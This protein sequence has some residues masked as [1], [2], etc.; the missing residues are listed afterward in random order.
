MLERRYIYQALRDPAAAGELTVGDLAIVTREKAQSA[1][2]FAKTLGNIEITQAVNQW[3]SGELM[4]LETR[5]SLEGLGLMRVALRQDSPIQMRGFTS[6]G[7]T[8]VETWALLNEL[9]KTVRLQG[10]ITVLD[11]V[12]VKDERFAPRN[13]RVRMRSTG[14]DRAKQI[15]S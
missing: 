8:E 12:N 15:M 4:T 10:A 13:T 5:Q 3:I 7:L 14:S 1:G 11:R 9:V 2:H 6:L